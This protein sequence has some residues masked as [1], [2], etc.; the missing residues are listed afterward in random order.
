M[1]ASNAELHILSFS[2]FLDSLK[3]H[4]I[5]K[6]ISQNLPEVKVSN[7]YKQVE[8][9]RILGKGGFGVVHQGK[10]KSNKFAIKQVECDH[11]DH[12]IW[13]DEPILPNSLIYQ[14]I[15]TD[16]GGRE[17]LFH[18]L[19]DQRAY[20][21]ILYNVYG[22]C[23]SSSLQ[24]SGNKHMISY[25]MDYVEGKDLQQ[26]NVEW[27]KKY[28][29]TDYYC[30]LCHIMNKIVFMFY[31]FNYAL[32]ISHNDIKPANIM[33]NTENNVYLIDF[34]S[35]SLFDFDQ[36]LYGG[37]SKAYTPSFVPPEWLAKR[38]IQPKYNEKPF[39]KKFTDT[40][41]QG[42]AK[43]DY[44]IYAIGIS[45]LSLISSNEIFINVMN[46]YLIHARADAGIQEVTDFS[47]DLFDTWQLAT[48]QGRMLD[49]L[50]QC[51]RV[52]S[53]QRIMLHDIHAVFHQCCL[54]T[55]MED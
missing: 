35:S 27:E 21:P 47:F 38:P 46:N 28:Q 29:K 24:L 51:L 52:K 4:N 7:P 50:Y 43:P 3:K 10:H 36:Y 15:Q 12:T 11:N 45:Y 17:Q 42:S 19:S 25:V 30:Q 18:E 32:K 22:T 23:P 40:F 26:L 9:E 53:E 55:Q 48:R 39:N 14:H 49:F 2:F 13:L 33:V 6:N 34:G 37:S 31:D 44:T 16:I 20:A 1:Q 8:K 5:K 41:A 54:L